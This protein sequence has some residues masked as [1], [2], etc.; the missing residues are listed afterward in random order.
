M[1][2]SPQ[3]HRHTQ[4]HTKLNTDTLSRFQDFSFNLSTRISPIKVY[5]DV[6]C[7]DTIG[8]IHVMGTQVA[9]WVDP[10]CSIPTLRQ[11]TDG[12]FILKGT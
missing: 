2:C 10:D 6:A 4:T 11:A 5:Q 7:F 9:Q 3:T 12:G 8:H 1:L